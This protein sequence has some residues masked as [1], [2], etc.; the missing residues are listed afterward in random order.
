MIYMPQNFFVRH[1]AFLHFLFIT[2]RNLQPLF[3]K[4]SMLL[5]CHN[6]D[7][8]FFLNFNKKMFFMQLLVFR[9][10]LNK[11]YEAIHIRQTMGKEI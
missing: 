4:A 9:R 8:R 3:Y 1:K 2:S 5:L 6:N 7:S 10:T 11:G